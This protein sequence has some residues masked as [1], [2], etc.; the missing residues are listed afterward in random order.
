MGMG[1]KRSLMPKAPPTLVQVRAVGNGSGYTETF[2]LEILDE[3]L[4]LVQ[5]N[6]DLEEVHNYLLKKEQAD[7]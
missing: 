3:L 6:S 1:E 4:S 2:K 7:A 5:L